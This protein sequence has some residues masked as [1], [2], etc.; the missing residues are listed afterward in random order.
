N[1]IYTEDNT[2][3]LEKYD[4]AIE[5]VSNYLA[6]NQG[7]K[8]TKAGRMRRDNMK[9]LFDN[10]SREKRH[11]SEVMKDAGYIDGKSNCDEILTAQTVI[12]PKEAQVDIKAIMDGDQDAYRIDT[13]GS[14]SFFKEMDNNDASAAAS[15]SYLTESLGLQGY[16]RAANKATIKSTKPGEDDMEGILYEQTYDVSYT[17]AFDKS[18]KYAKTEPPKL[19][20]QAQKKL[21]MIYAIDMIFG[22][23]ERINGDLSSVK[24]QLQRHQDKHTKRIAKSD[25]SL[26]T[27]QDTYDIVDV[28]ADHVDVLL[29]NTNSPAKVGEKE[30]AAVSKLSKEAKSLLKSI[31]ASDLPGILS[32][33]SDFKR[34]EFL[35]K[36][37]EDIQKLL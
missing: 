11:L 4:N 24:V 29:F 9:L 6:K 12:D 7:G 14:I 31:K 13:A 10:L 33:A 25:A 16:Y 20:E 15:I 8:W 23:G 19:T 17:Q 34:I 3:L 36:R 21:D 26:D 28:C 30:K 32:G 35:E 27:L 5:S 22:I 37:L 1:P 2:L 18:S